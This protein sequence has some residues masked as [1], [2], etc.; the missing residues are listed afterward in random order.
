MHN[1][2]MEIATVIEKPETQSNPTKDQI[3]PIVLT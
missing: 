2:D 3:N 1:S